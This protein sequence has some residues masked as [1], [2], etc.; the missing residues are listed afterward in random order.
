MNFRKVFN[1]ILS[2]EMKQFELMLIMSMHVY[3]N[4]IR[5]VQHQIKIF[6]NNLISIK[7]VSVR[8]LCLPYVISIDFWNYNVDVEVEASFVHMEN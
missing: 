6:I 5:N 7:F 1:L 2:Y 8:D 4:K 3:C